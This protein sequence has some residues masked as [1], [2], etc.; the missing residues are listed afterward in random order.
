MGLKI[1]TQAE[2]WKAAA[3][4]ASRTGPIRSFSCAAVGGI[5][6]L[7]KM[8]SQVL[9]L[10][11]SQGADCFLWGLELRKSVVCP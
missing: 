11:E 5:A 3:Y 6:P 7:Q 9:E 1:E 10:G 2:F 4:G 8:M